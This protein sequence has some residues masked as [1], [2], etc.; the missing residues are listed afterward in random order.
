MKKIFKKKI[1]KATVNVLNRILI[2]DAN[3]TS[4]SWLYQLKP[5]KGIERFKKVNQ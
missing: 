2:M 3:E 4:C 1:A 5:P